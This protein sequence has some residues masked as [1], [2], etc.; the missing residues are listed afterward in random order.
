[1]GVRNP[2]ELLGSL[3]SNDETERSAHGRYMKSAL[4]YLDR[5]RRAHMNFIVVT[6]AGALV[7]CSQLFAEISRAIIQQVGFCSYLLGGLRIQRVAPEESWSSNYLR[8]Q[9]SFVGM[10]N[11]TMLPGELSHETPRYVR[12][13]P[14]L[15]KRNA[16]ADSHSSKGSEE[17]I[18]FGN[19]PVTYARRKPPLLPPVP[20]DDT[21]SGRDSDVGCLCDDEQSSEEDKAAAKKPAEDRKFTKPTLVLQSKLFLRRSKGPPEPGPVE[22]AMIAQGA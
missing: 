7:A 16:S 12:R 11:I 6:H 13:N 14:F 5:A 2:A 19:S 17:D 4:T 21:E 10:E 9:V 18:V 8:K 20:A 1:V 3:P 22:L 15:R